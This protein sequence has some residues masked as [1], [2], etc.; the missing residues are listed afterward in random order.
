M[1]ET[2]IKQC[3]GRDITEYPMQLGLTCGD[4]IAFLQQFD[5]SES[6]GWYMIAD[7]VTPYVG[8]HDGEV[9]DFEDPWP[10]IVTSFRPYDEVIG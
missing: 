1:S 3:K 5:P 8:L 10:M 6:I 9:G 2:N 4:V 7:D